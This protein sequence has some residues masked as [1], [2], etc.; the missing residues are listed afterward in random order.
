LGSSCDAHACTAACDPTRPRARDREVARV[1]D[2]TRFKLGL[3]AHNHTTMSYGQCVPNEFANAMVPYQPPPV[4]PHLN[5]T[6]LLPET[7]G[8][9]NVTETLA[10]LQIETL[11]CDHCVYVFI[12][13]CALLI[14]ALLLESVPLLVPAGLVWTGCLLCLELYD[15]RVPA[16]IT[17][18]IA[19]AAFCVFV[20]FF[21]YDKRRDKQTW[22]HL[23]SGQEPPCVIRLLI[24]FGVDVAQTDAN[25]GDGHTAL[26]VACRWDNVE[27][28]R[29]LLRSGANPNKG[30]EAKRWTPLHL[31]A[32]RGHAEIVEELL[33]AGAAVNR[34]NDIGATPLHLAALNNEPAC[35]RLL[36]SAGA[37][38]DVRGRVNKDGAV[39]TPAYRDRAD[40]LPVFARSVCHR[41]VLGISARRRPAAGP[42]RPALDD[43]A[44]YGPGFAMAFKRTTAAFQ[45]SSSRQNVREVAAPWTR[46]FRGD[47]RVAASTWRFRA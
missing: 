16:G 46:I 17:F 6:A 15:P 38:I 43:P 1:E 45:R 33:L 10:R 3:D 19:L 28:A 44:A 42:P 27:A 24:R 34:A 4:P 7:V 29:Q 32:M 5:L 9:L 26:Y 30:N 12:A 25:N 23:A 22:L 18:V 47:S 37:K 11:D 39:C 2:A 13:C 40:I 21:F 36:V 14:L 35:V 31:A 41:P 8:R 20:F